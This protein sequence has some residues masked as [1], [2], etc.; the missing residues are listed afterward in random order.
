MSNLGDNL[1]KA[2]GPPEPALDVAGLQNRAAG[3]AR[4]KRRALAGGAVAALLL[5]GGVAFTAIQGVDGGSQVVAAGEGGDGPTSTEA[6]DT[7]TA[8]T[9]TTE[10]PTTTIVGGTTPVGPTVTVDPGVED[11]RDGSSTTV[12]PPATTVPPA[13]GVDSLRVGGTYTGKEHYRLDAT[14]CRASGNTMSHSLLSTLTVTADYDGTADPGTWTYKSDYCSRIVG[15]TWR[16]TGTFAIGLPGGETLTGTVDDETAYPT[17]GEPYTVKITS[18]SG[19]YEG[20]TGVCQLTV[21]ISDKAFGS[22][23]QSG[24]FKC[25]I[26]T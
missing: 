23:T 15:D 25:E 12:I 19:R 7:T 4:T 2:A 24:D 8:T 17:E 10:A 18:G 22:Q 16:G 21:H 3:R 5:V 9:P 14:E 1:D 6:P 26:S 20:A 11:P 13:A